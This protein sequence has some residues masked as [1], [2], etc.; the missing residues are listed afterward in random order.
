MHV[1]CR[2]LTILEAKKQEGGPFTSSEEVDAYLSDSS[3]VNEKKAKL[4]RGEVTYARD[5]S[6][7]L[8]RNHAVFRIFNASVKPRRLLTPSEFVENLKVLLGKRA[9]RT[10]ITLLLRIQTICG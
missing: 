1:E 4:M 6:V 7:S 8:P 3:V 9:G 2:K 5:T 10:Y